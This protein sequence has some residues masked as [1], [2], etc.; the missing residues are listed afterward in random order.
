MAYYGHAF[1]LRLVGT[2]GAIKKTGLS[3]D[4]APGE[5]GFF[6]YE[7]HKAIGLAGTSANPKKM[8]LIGQGSF[9][10]KDQLSPFYGGL[11]ETVLT[12][13]INPAF[14]SKFWK[15]EPKR[16]KQHIVSL[17][18]NGIVGCNCIDTIK[19]ENYT[20]RVEVEN[21]PALR[22][23]ARNLYKEFTYSAECD[24][25]AGDPGDPLVAAKFFASQINENVELSRFVKA[26]IIVDNPGV[27]TTGCDVF[28]LNIC[29]E[30]SIVDLGRIQAY[31]NNKDIKLVGRSGSISTYEIE[32]PDGGSVADYNTP[33]IA[34]GESCTC[35]EGYTLVL[36]SENY[37]VSI[38]LAGTE[39]LSDATAQDTYAATI[40][41]KYF[42]AITFDGAA[43]VATDQIT[44][45][46]H[47]F[48][49]GTRVTYADG[50]GTQV[51]GL[52]DGTD[53][54]VIKVDD[55]TISLATTEANA[56]A[57]T[58]ITL[59]DGIG[60]AHTLTPVIESSFVNN[61]NGTAMVRLELA[62]GTVI[63]A[64]D[65]DTVVEAGSTGNTCT[66]AQ[67]NTAW[68]AAGERY[69]GTRKLCITLD[70]CNSDAD[71]R[72]AEVQ[73]FLA[74]RSDISGIQLYLAGDDPESIDNGDCGEVIELT[75]TSICE[76][77]P[78]CKG[79][80]LPEYEDVPSFDG[81]SWNECPCTT[82]VPYT[83]C[84]GLLLK[85][86]YVDTKF[87]DCSFSPNDHYELEPIEV[88]VSLQTN[89]ETCPADRTK[90][91]ETI[92]RQGKQVQGT[93]ETAL[94]DYMKWMNYKL[95]SFCMD[96]R[97]R[98]VEDQNHLEVIDRSKM[99][100]HY[101]LTHSIPNYTRGSMTQHSYDQHYTLQ[102][103]FEESV[104]TSEFEAIL[105][106]YAALNG[107]FLESV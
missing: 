50:G 68:V 73:S 8:F 5:I 88:R 22:A 85:G 28:K 32:V 64:Q 11:Q 99:Y 72:L 30:G 2:T 60:A 14:I 3:A 55:D 52:V 65:A 40:A 63:V 41:T 39:D 12:R 103:I 91:S 10:K 16:A 7:S 35:P 37:I 95:E 19:G 43:D 100:K 31:Y 74:N 24:G 49:T 66:L 92:L 21:S 104:D 46:A 18:Y 97:I 96:P 20:I 106:S 86:A 101:F 81:R 34:I 87:G 42:P 78:D 83:G 27:L 13:G 70:K 36:G 48:V 45:V 15:V 57:G 67:G 47:G 23:Y 90:W 77:A 58:V 82:T 1:N 62:K 69:I 94:R 61:A 17:G 56:K 71:S 33:D 93:G 98:E 84:V 29:D 25:T 89:S 6:D 105:G 59:A 107:V 76:P 9:H 80:L 51:V 44:E 4:L 38:P 53:Y 54:Y 102:F 26:G 79:Y 75:Q